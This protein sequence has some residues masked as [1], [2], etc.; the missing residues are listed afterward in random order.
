MLVL[1]QVVANGKNIKTLTWYGHLV[2]PDIVIPMHYG[3]F[4]VLTRTPDAFER[5]LANLEENAVINSR[6]AKGADASSGEKAAGNGDRQ[7]GRI[8]IQRIN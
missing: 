2:N 4:P 7:A 5:A 3:N 6:G 1:S 8:R